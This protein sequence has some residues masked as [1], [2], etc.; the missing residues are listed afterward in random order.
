MV[1][2]TSRPVVHRGE[3]TMLGSV[4]RYGRQHISPAEHD[5]DQKL[6]SAF[7]RSEPVKQHIAEMRDALDPHVPR[8]RESD[9]KQELDSVLEFNSYE[10]QFS[11]A[12]LCYEKEQAKFVNSLQPPSLADRLANPVL[13][14]SKRVT[15][16][17]RLALIRQALDSFG[18]DRSDMQKMFHNDMIGA[19]AKHIFKDDLE[20]ELDDLLIELGIEELHSE[21]M[22]VTPRRFGK[23]TAVAMF[24]V[25]MAFGVEG[26]EQA[27]FS[28]GRRA[29]QKLLEL[30]YR[31]LCKIP[32]MRDS[33]I[34]HN[35]ETIW[36]R[37]PHGDDDI[38]KIFSYPSN[39]RI[40][41]PPSLPLS[42]PLSKNRMGAHRYVQ[43]FILPHCIVCV[44][45]GPARELAVH[46]LCAESAARRL[47]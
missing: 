36:I 15:G 22:A 34:K 26:I 4:P 38:R 44:A 24:V 32:G 5:R 40:S 12:H 42:S 6:N 18:L 23:T 8:P 45:P 39:V 43:I 3:Q 29:S 46:R 1:V 20:T 25:A 35:V 2:A 21:F 9:W 11:K 14:D 28:T 31:F 47:D 41:F 37:G 17:E 13:S 7:L 16:R 19:C 10:N 30:I 33:I 27:I